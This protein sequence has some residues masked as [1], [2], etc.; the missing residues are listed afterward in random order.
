MDRAELINFVKKVIKELEKRPR[1][2]KGSILMHEYQLPGDNSFLITLEGNGYQVVNVNRIY[3][4]YQKDQ[5]TWEMALDV[6][7]MELSEEPE[8]LPLEPPKDINLQ[9]VRAELV[10]Q[11]NPSVQEQWVIKQ[12]LFDMALYFYYEGTGEFWEELEDRIERR[13]MEHSN[14]TEHDLFLAAMDNLT[15]QMVQIKKEGLALYHLDNAT[16][17]LS[18]KLGSY[19]GLEHGC[20]DYPQQIDSV[21][22]ITEQDLKKEYPSGKGQ[23]NWLAIAET[24]LG[25]ENRKQKNAKLILSSWLYWYEDGTLTKLK[26]GRKTKEKKELKEWI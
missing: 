23:E 9:T 1:F 7:A 25:I 15:Y 10:N 12:S 4:A 20:Y 11:E 26:N 24:R 18:P 17:L 6:V 2:P 22:L 19:P 8:V 14:F 21:Y 5:W 3:K 13:D 16:A